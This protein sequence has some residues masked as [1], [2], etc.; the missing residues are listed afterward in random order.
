MAFWSMA[1]AHPALR[2]VQSAGYRQ[3][4]ELVARLLT[5]AA[6]R[7]EVAAGLDTG[8]VG[9]QLMCLVDGLLMQGTLE[10]A[11]LPATRQAELLDAAVARLAPPSAHQ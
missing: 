7:G 8:S 9:E 6:E 3:W 1:V 5:E 4:R 2:E 10:P 11:R